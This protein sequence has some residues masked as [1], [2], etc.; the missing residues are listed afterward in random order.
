MDP[1]KKHMAQPKI[2]EGTRKELQDY[3]NRQPE[4]RRFRL[5][6]VEAGTPGVNGIAEGLTEATVGGT[7]SRYRADLTPEERIRA[8][9]VAAEKN[10]GLPVLPPEAFDRESLY[11]D[12]QELH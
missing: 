3:L 11:A 10:R 5:V 8:L 4:Q 12:D 6:P 2:P 1:E 9:D 7:A